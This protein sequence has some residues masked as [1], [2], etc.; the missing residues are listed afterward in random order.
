MDFVLSDNIDITLAQNYSEI[1]VMQKYANLY[2]SSSRYF[3]TTFLFTCVCFPV[4][5]MPGGFITDTFASAAWSGHSSLCCRDIRRSVWK[6]AHVHA[7]VSRNREAFTLSHALGCP[8][9]N[10]VRGPLGL[11]HADDAMPPKV[12]CRTPGR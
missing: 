1:I 3:Q 12:L 11:R 10:I 6:H 2:K 9:A 4:T 7:Y 5:I 8:T